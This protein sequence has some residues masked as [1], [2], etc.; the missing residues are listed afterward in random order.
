MGVKIV[1]IDMRIQEFL[2]LGFQFFDLLLDGDANRFCFALLR[3]PHEQDYLPEQPHILGLWPQTVEIL[4]NSRSNLS[5]G[6]LMLN[7]AS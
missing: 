1:L 7:R 2:P 6:I 4:V 5:L 3:L